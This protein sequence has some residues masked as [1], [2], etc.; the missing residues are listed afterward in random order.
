MNKFLHLK[1]ISEEIIDLDSPSP[2]GRK[3]KA[4]CI[5]DQ[6]PSVPTRPTPNPG[7]HALGLP[8]DVEPDSLEAAL[9]HQMNVWMDQ[10]DM[11]HVGFPAIGEAPDQDDDL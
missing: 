8:D 6:L 1:A 10:D 3:R 9:S 7:N 5:D 4:T 2:C 11:E